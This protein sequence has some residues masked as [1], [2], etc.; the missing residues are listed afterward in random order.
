MK[1]NQ[2]YIN[3]QWINSESEEFIPVLNPAT[4]EVIAEVVKATESEVDQAVAAAK[5]AF[6]AWNQLAVSERKSFLEK[7]YEILDRRQA[8]VAATVVLELGSPIG[9]TR[10]GQV[11]LSL[12]EMKATLEEIDNFK[13]EEEYHGSTIIKEGFGPIACITPWNWPLNQIQRKLTPALLAGNTLVVKPAS[14]T[15]L[16]ALLFAEIIHEAGLPKGVFNLV[17]G[18]GSETGGYLAA[19]PDIP[20]IS[21]T[22]STEVGRGLYEAASKSIKKLIMELG[23]KSPLIYLPGGDLDLAVDKA[24]QAIINNQ[25]Q[26]C[27]ALTRF[28]VPKDQLEVTKEKIL[29]YLKDITLGDPT[30]EETKIG[31]LISKEQMDKVLAYIEKGKAEGAKLLTGGN[32]VGDKG[33]FVEPTVFYDVKNDMTI[34]QEEIF[35][36]VSCL[37]AYDSLEE[38]IEMANDT[39]YGLSGAVVGPQEEALAVA[40]QL[41]T[42]NV[43]VN[44]GIKSAKVPFG[45]YK[46]SGLGR[47]VGLYGVED[48]LEVKAIIK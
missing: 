1:K 48:Y 43:F 6:P 29:A 3:G 13:F 8:E 2:L 25:G 36:P 22:G 40:R 11:K 37:I 46:E 38:A 45:G 39:T 19:H 34:A 15:P 24:M 4:E 17:T 35:G 31:A 26:S 23:G 47:E 12:V 14:N 28:F 42:G 44:E 33:F 5:E 16:T 32:R 18:S 20:L 9:F 10:G 7:I 41:R 21:F 30:K 27:S